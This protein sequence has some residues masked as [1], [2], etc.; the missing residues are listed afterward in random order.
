MPR[1]RVLIQRRL[2]RID[3][4]TPAQ[5]FQEVLLQAVEDDLGRQPDFFV[6]LADGPVLNPTS[7]PRIEDPPIGRLFDARYEADRARFQ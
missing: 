3:G 4:Y 1:L 7:P 2:P 6:R 5:D